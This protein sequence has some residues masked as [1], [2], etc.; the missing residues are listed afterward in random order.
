MTRDTVSRARVTGGHERLP[1]G[2]VTK[3]CEF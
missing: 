2:C 3:G 1:V